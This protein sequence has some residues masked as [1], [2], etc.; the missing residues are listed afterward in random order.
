[1]KYVVLLYEKSK[2]ESL[3]L[4]LHALLG[5]EETI[6]K[7]LNQ[8]DNLKNIMIETADKIDHIL[9]DKSIESKSDFVKLF[10]S[11]I[12]EGKNLES[13]RNSFQINE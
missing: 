10:K 6:E 13:L 5:E 2:I 12:S 9:N 4:F 3:G 8:S 7:V 11:S 1:M